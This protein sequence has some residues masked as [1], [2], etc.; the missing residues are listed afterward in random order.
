MSSGLSTLVSFEPAEGGVLLVGVTSNA[1][2]LADDAVMGGAMVCGRVKR[3][4]SSECGGVVE[5]G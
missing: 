2:R 4:C 3:T 1:G 5:S